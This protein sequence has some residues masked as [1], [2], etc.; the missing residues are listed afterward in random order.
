MI[1]LR[2]TERTYSPAIVVISLIIANVLIFLY[3]V[4]LGSGELNR[5]IMRH[6]IV[7]DRLHWTL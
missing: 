7:P 2:S 6:G 5:F 4:A 1:P 3:E